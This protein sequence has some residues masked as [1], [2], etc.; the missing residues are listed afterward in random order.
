MRMNVS[1]AVAPELTTIHSHVRSTVG[2]PLHGCGF[3]QR[4]FDHAL[5]FYRDTLHYRS[6]AFLLVWDATAVLPSLGYRS[7]SDT[8]VGL[9]IPDDE[10][11]TLDLRVGES[12]D[13]FLIRIRSYQ[14]AT[15]VEIMLLVPLSPNCPPYLLAAFAQ[16]H[17][18]TADTLARRM[19]TAREELERRGALVV[20]VAADGAS[21]NFKLL[22]T[23]RQ[24][25]TATPFI[26]SG[27]P[28][29]SSNAENVQLPGR[30]VQYLGKTRVVPDL[31]ILDPV[32]LLSLL[33]NAP[34][35]QTAKMRIGA[36]EIRPQLVRDALESQLGVLGLEVQ[37]SVRSTDFRLRI[38]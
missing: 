31:G 36:F 11:G 23:L 30:V 21:G 19:L 14:L 13:A 12:L 25:V 37:L 1:Y 35:R 33:R 32:H 16:S 9:T 18:Q 29:L 38:A 10:L 28:T 5:E 34:L 27:V 20:G 4:R 22:H 6:C 15:Q 24:R 2:E 17:P 26:F 7:A 3:S 8:V